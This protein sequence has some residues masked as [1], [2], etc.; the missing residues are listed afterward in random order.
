MGAITSY[1]DVA[2]ITL[3]VFW[4]F[5]A[6]LVIYLQRESKREGHPLVPDDLLPGSTT[7]V[8][9]GWPAV[10][11]P[12]EYHLHDGSVVKAPADTGDKRDLALEP[13]YAWP[14]TPFD[15]TG[16]PLVDGVGPAS[17]AARQDVPDMTHEHEPK[18]APMRNVPG[19]QVAETDPDPR[20]WDVLAADGEVAGKICEIWVDVEEVLIRYLEVDLEGW[21]RN[22]LLPMGFVQIEPMRRRV[23]VTS[24]T[25]DQ[26]SRVPLT[27]NPD[28]V[29][30]L[31][32]DKIMGYFG[33][34]H[35][36]AMPDRKA[37]LI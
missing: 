22:V 21:E 2:Q 15:P 4:G 37:P 25:A 30:R 12:K 3:Y 8:H 20:G 11:K 24:I 23:R 10:P 13:T 7:T 31:E 6:A 5:F 18:I 1:I 19:Y 35:L 9:E 29:T 28:L 16:D 17:W 34:G 26:F 36:Y 14:G 27:A 32:E 33:G